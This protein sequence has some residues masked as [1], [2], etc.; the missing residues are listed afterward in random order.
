MQCLMPRKATVVAH[1][2]TLARHPMH[3]W[4]VTSAE[5]EEAGNLFGAGFARFGCV[6]N[7]G[8]NIRYDTRMI[9]L[10]VIRIASASC[11]ISRWKPKL[12]K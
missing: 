10:N 12:S 7:N 9:F 2:L 6:H 3:P 5:H 1:E 8:S 11:A 4:V